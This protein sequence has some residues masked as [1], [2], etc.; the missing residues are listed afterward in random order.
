MIEEFMPV[1]PQNFCEA[2]YLAANPDVA[3]S[4]GA[5]GFPSGRTHFELYGK[6]ESHRRQSASVFSAQRKIREAR[7]TS[8]L[9]DDMPHR[10]EGR[11]FDF[12]TDELR[13]QFNIKFTNLA[14]KNMY[15]GDTL[16]LIDKH[17]DGLVL[18]CGAGLRPVYYEN[19]VNFEIVAYPSTDV[20]GVGEVLPFRD[21]SFD[22]VVSKAVLEH[23]QDPFR[24][25]KEILRVLKPG[26]DLLCCVPLLQPVHGYPHHYYNMTGQGLINLFGEEITVQR[27]E[28]PDSTLPIWSLQWILSSWAKGLKGDTRRQ[29]M[30]MKIR[31]LLASPETYLDAPFVRDL[32]AKKNMELASATV[33]H[34][35]KA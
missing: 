13:G 23:V 25:A 27:H 5:G 16:S 1:T 31:D 21:A 7:I 17:R 32:S 28:V 14:S 8:V 4:L 24:C 18:D 34:A 12:L 2:A 29:F 9:R 30:D 20:R 33:I 19:V 3:N 11:I 10:K 26:G 22:A 35:V 6:N 15:D